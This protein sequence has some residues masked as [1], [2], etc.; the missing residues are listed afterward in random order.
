ML[1]PNHWDN[2]NIGNK[3]Y[4]FIL[5]GCQNP[6]PIRGFFNEFLKEELTEHRRVFEA[7]GS[8]MEIPYSENQLSGIGFSSTVRNS[9]ICKVTG[10]FER[11][12]KINF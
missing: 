8:R 10:A 5:E 9:V 11:V 1:S 3:H 6:D 12:I 2:I 4:F 7:L